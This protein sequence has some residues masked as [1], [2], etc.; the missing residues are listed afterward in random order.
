MN[1]TTLT[2]Y[3]TWHDISYLHSK[4][5]KMIRMKAIVH[6]EKSE[7]KKA[8][9]LLEQDKKIILMKYRN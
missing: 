8:E 1:K 3:K 6:K 9:K 7:L 2:S 4:I 5:L